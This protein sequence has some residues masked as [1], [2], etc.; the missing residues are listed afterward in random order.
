M[1]TTPIFPSNDSLLAEALTQGWRKQ[2]NE[3]MW[4]WLT[5]RG[6]TQNTLNDKIIAA[7]LNNFSF[8]L[9]AT[10]ITVLDSDG[11]SFSV[12]LAVLDSDGNS[13]TITTAFLDSDGNS[14]TVI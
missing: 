8:E 10:T 9:G 6:F 7:S 2:Y 12:P 14:F 13:F 11:N 5:A 3:A 4:D 1:A